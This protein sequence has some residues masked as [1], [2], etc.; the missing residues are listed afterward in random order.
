MSKSFIL[1]NPPT[2]QLSFYNAF[3]ITQYILYV[4]PRKFSYLNFYFNNNSQ[5]WFYSHLSYY[6]DDQLPTK[7]IVIT[8][9]LLNYHLSTI[10]IYVRES[11]C[12]LPYSLD[13]TTQY[14]FCDSSYSL[15]I[16]VRYSYCDSPYSLSN[17]RSF[18]L[19]GLLYIH[20]ILSLSTP[21]VIYHT[22]YSPSTFNAT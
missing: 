9:H 8:S 5:E 22:I 21:Y 17:T 6:I 11:L 19:Y 7:D 15:H 18:K 3:Q 4:L 1:I 14:L 13:I 2:T 12:G 16:S 20:R 10:D